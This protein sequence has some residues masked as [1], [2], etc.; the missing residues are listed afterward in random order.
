MVKFNLRIGDSMKNKKQKKEEQNKKL[1]SGYV[2]LVLLFVATIFLVLL[3]RNWYLTGVNY[4]L[5][6]P[7]IK[8]TLTQEIHSEEIYN[9]IRENENSVIYV[10]VVTD[11]EC[12][13]FEKLFNEVITEKHLENTI[14]YLNLTEEDNIKGFLKDF[15][16]FYDTD[17]T[18]YPSIIVFSDGEVKDLL[19]AGKDKLT[20]EDAIDFLDNNDIVSV[21]Y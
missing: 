10:G 3:L 16:K 9:Y 8:E 4:E 6:I 20:K 12:R 7:I 5:S 17:L 1:I 18:G 2:K 15:N 21:D 14:T 11:S 19:V 13:E